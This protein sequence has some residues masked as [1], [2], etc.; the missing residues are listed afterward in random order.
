LLGGLHIS[1]VI[2]IHVCIHASWLTLIARI[3]IYLIEVILATPIPIPAICWEIRWLYRCLDGCTRRRTT[4]IVVLRLVRPGNR[5]LKITLR[6][7]LICRSRRP[8]RPKM[9]LLLTLIIWSH[10]TFTLEV[11]PSTHISSAGKNRTLDLLLEVVLIA[12][13]RRSRTLVVLQSFFTAPWVI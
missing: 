4:L 9:V 7:K 8:L 11:M 5:T 1:C 12:L 3:S 6:L 13:S 2:R 10:G